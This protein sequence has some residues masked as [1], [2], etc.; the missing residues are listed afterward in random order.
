[1]TNLLWLIVSGLSR[2][3]EIGML[4]LS[5]LLISACAGVIP[6]IGVFRYSLAE[7]GKDL[8]LVTRHFSSI[9]LTVCTVFSWKP[10]DWGYLGLIVVWVNLYSVA[11]CSNYLEEY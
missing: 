4:D 5:R 7:L 8:A 10:P 6:S 9:F 1:M 11:N 3:W 2:C